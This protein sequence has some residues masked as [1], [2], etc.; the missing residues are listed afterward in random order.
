M[1]GTPFCD[2]GPSIG[3]NKRYFD[4][5]ELWLNTDFNERCCQRIQRIYAT[6]QI[7][8]HE[9]HQRAAALT[10]LLC[11][12]K[13]ARTWAVV[14]VSR[15]CHHDAWS[16]YCIILVSLQM[17]EHQGTDLSR[18]A[19]AGRQRFPT[20]EWKPRQADSWRIECASSCRADALGSGVET[21]HNPNVADTSSRT[22]LVIAGEAQRQ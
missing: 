20:A 4:W 13:T 10:Q 22:R 3:Y 7:P 6:P 1:S 18:S 21:E 16:I 5:K 14:C 2:W 9:R 19:S 12:D 15:S 11:E 17:S 8:N